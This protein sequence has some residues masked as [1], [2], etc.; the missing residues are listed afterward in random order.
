MIAPDSRFKKIW[1][2]FV[3]LV[4]IYTALYI[5]I[6]IVFGIRPRGIFLIIELVISAVYIGDMVI[7]LRTAYFQRMKLV[8]DFKAISRRYLKKWFWFDILACIPFGLIFSFDSAW[9]LFPAVGVLRMLRTA[10]LIH[11]SVRIRRN[12][13][14]NP[15]IIRMLFLILFVVIFA[16][17]VSCIWIEIGSITPYGDTDTAIKINHYIQSY[18]WTITTLTTVGYGDLLPD[19]E[20]SLQLTFVIVLELIGAAIY[21]FIIGNIANLI[22]NID[23]AKSQ[24]KEKV[25]KMN[26]FLKYHAVPERLTM[27]V[28]DYYA[29][30]WDSR[31]G[32]EERNV[33]NDLPLSLKTSVSIQINRDM[34]EKVPI[35]KGASNAML[36]EIILNLEPTIYTPKDYIVKEGDIGYDM[37]FIKKGS[38]DVVNSDGSIKFATLLEGQFFG[39]IALLLQLP[40]TANIIANEYCD[41]YKLNKETFDSILDRYPEFKKSIAEMAEK[42]RLEML[43][44]KAK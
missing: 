12:S 29:Y 24:H 15:S 20:S 41:L 28:N 39:E 32:Y 11:S 13:N 5:P 43:A 4:T 18:Y 42:R 2:F 33:I 44:S 7:T 14:M 10:K 3:F 16:H 36:E 37:F 26:S 34:I 8:T 19:K 17:F 38:V 30:L 9:M 35:F 25:D 6:S 21:G 27:K 1:D 22:A 31:R 40:R 23:I